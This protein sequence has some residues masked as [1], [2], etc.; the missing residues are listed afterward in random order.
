MLD[1]WSRDHY[2]FPDKF[3]DLPPKIFMGIQLS[4]TVMEY[5]HSI[6]FRQSQTVWGQMFQGLQ[7]LLCLLYFLLGNKRPF[8]LKLFNHLQFFILPHSASLVFCISMNR[9]YLLYVFCFGISLFLALTLVSDLLKK[10]TITE[11][12]KKER[13]TG[14]GVFLI[15]EGVLS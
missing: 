5:M 8:G 6:P 10:I 2:C 13:T 14:T 1:S 4:C 7:W 12:L 11:S 9:L 15:I 3:V